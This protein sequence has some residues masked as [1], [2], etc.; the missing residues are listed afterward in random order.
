[1]KNSLCF[2]V[3]ASLMA[4][5]FP[6]RAE[7]APTLPIDAALKLAQDYLKGQPNPPAIVAL[8]LE[9]ATLR[10]RKIWYAKWSQPIFGGPKPEVGLQIEMNGEFVKV[11]TGAG[12]P[13]K[14]QRRYGVRDMR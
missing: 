6:A 4:L 5:A 9:E 14:G 11:V 2:A 1:M 3:A 7:K 10:G 8:T 12:E 13:G